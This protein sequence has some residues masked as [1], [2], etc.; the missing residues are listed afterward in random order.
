MKKGLSKLMNNKIRSRP[1]WVIV[2]ICLFFLAGSSRPPSHRLPATPDG[3]AP[4]SPD[5]PAA[6]H[7]IPPLPQGMEQPQALS[8]ET[9]AEVLSLASTDTK[10][11]AMNSIDNIESKTFGWVAYTGN[12]G[13]YNFDEA[14]WTSG[15][16]HL[17][18]EYAWYYPA[19]VF[20]YRNSEKINGTLIH[21]RWVGV[22]LKTNKIIF[23]LNNFEIPPKI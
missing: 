12:V 13:V 1:V 15:E 8:A 19:I 17:P 20:E 5:N 4:E 10:I 23:T 3:W 7:W 16:F 6:P 9:W 22:D 18:S 21:G 11:T 14:E 2:C